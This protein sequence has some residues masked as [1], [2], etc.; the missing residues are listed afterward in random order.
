MLL[1]KQPSLDGAPLPPEDELMKD[2]V[3]QTVN[4]GPIGTGSAN[5]TLQCEVE[6]L[7][8]K[9]DKFDGVIVDPICL[10]KDVPTF[11]TRLH[12]SLANWKSKQKK[13][14]WLKLPTENANL[15]PSAIEAGFTYHHAEPQYVMLTYWIPDSPCTLPPNASHQ[16]GIGAFVL[17]KKGEILAV[18]EKN[19]PLKGLGI[20][21]FPTGLVNQAEDIFAGAIREVKEETGI[22]AE[23]VQVLGFRQGHHVAFEKSDLFFVCILR[24][25]SSEIVVQESELEAAKWMPLDEFTTQPFYRQR[26]MMRKMVE[27]CIAS[28]KG[29]YKGFSPIELDTDPRMRSSVFYCSTL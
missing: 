23:F 16:V 4:E 11:V 17:N 25:L 29:I 24:P 20:W 22:D 8:A 28:S 18:Q 3:S 5:A 10:P 26:R 15:V 1:A 19:G 12:S 21:K 27:I 6:Q 2:E 7:V 14:V 13:G 9:A